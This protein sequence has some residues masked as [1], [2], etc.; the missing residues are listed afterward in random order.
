MSAPVSP[1]GLAEGTI[2]AFEVHHWPLVKAYADRIGL[3]GLINRL[4][5]SRMEVE[6]GLIVLGTRDLINR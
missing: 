1:A 3:V 4:V 2:E 6:P 5:P